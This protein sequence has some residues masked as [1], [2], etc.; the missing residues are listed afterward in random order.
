MS[1]TA[2]R[3]GYNLDSFARQ[4]SKRD[5]DEFDLIVAMDNE[6]LRDLADIFR[7]GGE[8]IRLMGTFLQ[9][10]GDV[11]VIQEVPDPYYG[12]RAG[13]ERV[14]DMIEEACPGIL[15]HCLD[16]LGMD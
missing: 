14:I 4:V 3:R 6:N 2:S 7:A 11:S 5:I 12:G 1:A 13:F 16:R 8:H 15:S 9:P 10:S